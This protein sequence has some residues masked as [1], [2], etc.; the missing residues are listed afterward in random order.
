MTCK[1]SLRGTV[2]GTV[3]VR[4]ISLCSYCKN[5]ME[6]HKKLAPMEK[7]LVEIHR[8]LGVET[9]TYYMIVKKCKKFKEMGT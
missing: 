2:L 5:Y 1:I 4:E 3:E 6:C 7:K 9:V 8:K